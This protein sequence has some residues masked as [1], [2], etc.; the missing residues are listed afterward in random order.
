M[1]PRLCLIWIA[2]V[3]L[4]PGSLCSAVAPAADSQ[5]D[6]SRQFGST[7]RPPE[8]PAGETTA[9][10]QPMVV[11][12]NDESFGTQALLKRDDKP[13]PF[14]VF[15]D[16]SAFVTNNVA[17][18]SRDPL[19][20]AFL[21]ANFGLSCQRN[22][23][24]AL[25]AEFTLK[26]GIFRYEK[27]SE[28]DFQSIDA[29][30]GVNYRLPKLW[31]VTLFA[32]YNFTDL[33]NGDT[34]DH[35]FTN[36]TVTFGAQRALVLGR[37]HNVFAGVSGTVSLAEPRSAQRDEGSFY[38]G[39]HV[40][41][42]RSLGADAFYRAAWHVYRENDRVDINHTVT[43]SVRFSVKDWLAVIAAG[44]ASFNDSNKPAFDYTAIS[45]GLGLSLDLKF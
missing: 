32:R 36:N 44:Y 15:A 8:A 17:L 2:I 34:G 9:P 39:Y 1:F 12:A 20:D 27:Y 28:L 4:L 24:D 11:D 13:K 42:T 23:A 38:T 16:V 40:D 21:V 25:S 29:G 33:Y 5:I 3:L 14:S 18:T 26:G 19:R 43:L 41:L 22:V 35:F 37:A 30:L 10:I 6:Q 31:D 7:F 45:G